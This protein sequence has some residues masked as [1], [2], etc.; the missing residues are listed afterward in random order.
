MTGQAS[1]AV[2]FDFEF[3][4][5]SGDGFIATLPYIPIYNAPAPPGATA[6]CTMPM[7]PCVGVQ[8]LPD[9]SILVDGGLDVF[10]A[11]G[12]DFQLADTDARGTLYY[13]F[14]NGAFGQAGTFN[15]IFG[16]GVTL[17]ISG[18]PDGIQD[19]PPPPI[20]IDP[21]PTPEPATWGLMLAGFGLAGAS[22]R[23]RR[24][25]A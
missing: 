22:L 21:L 19:V 24:A 2:T 4:D 17:T 13:Y 10:D 25:R 7:L 12:L 5:G 18:S 11:V 14:A 9:T 1:A 15:D 3:T 8:F 23:R 20:P 6:G 16:S